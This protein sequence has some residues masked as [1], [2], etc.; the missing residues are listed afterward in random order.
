MRSKGGPVLHRG[1]IV[2]LA[3]NNI[4]PSVDNSVIDTLYIIDRFTIYKNSRYT[5]IYYYYN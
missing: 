3:T 2:V 5:Y 1:D 4:I